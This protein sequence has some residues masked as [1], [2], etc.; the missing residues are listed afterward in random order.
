MSEDSK[1]LLE[2]LYKLNNTELFVEFVEWLVE[3]NNRVLSKLRSE[4][5]NMILIFQLQGADKELSDIIRII[6]TARDKLI[7][8][9]KNNQVKSGR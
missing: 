2:I 1:R 5:D 6:K 9:E 4:S 3:R 8:I 7:E